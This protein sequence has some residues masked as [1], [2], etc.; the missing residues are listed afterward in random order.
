MSSEEWSQLTLEE[1]RAELLA[2]FEEE[3]DREQS[4]DG[5]VVVVC[6][7]LVIGGLIWIGAKMNGWTW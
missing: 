3:R 4:R 5:L 7:L 2:Q 6:I 1:Q